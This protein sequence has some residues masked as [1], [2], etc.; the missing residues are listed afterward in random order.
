[1]LVS[2]CLAG[3]RTRYDGEAS[4]HERVVEL[5]KDGKAL[6]VCPEQLGGLPTP[7]Y[8]AEIDSG[9]GEDVLNGLS[10]VLNE[11]GED[12]TEKFIRGATETLKLAE[13]MG[14]KKAIMKERSPSCGVNSIIRGGNE[15]R[16]RGV[17]TAFLQSKGIEVISSDSL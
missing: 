5:L 12:V 3:L 14:I 15:V 9:S 6:P 10:R 16:G 11:K 13:A 8:K 1:M 2:A 4:P 17:T 7:R